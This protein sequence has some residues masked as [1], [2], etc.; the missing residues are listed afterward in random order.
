MTVIAQ[1]DGHLKSSMN[2][3]APDHD[4][5]VDKVVEENA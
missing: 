5:D 3:L 2:S 4:V 1:Q